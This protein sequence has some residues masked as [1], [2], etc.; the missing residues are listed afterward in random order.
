MLVLGVVGWGALGVLIGALMRRLADRITRAHRANPSTAPP[1][2]FEAITAALFAG[3]AWRTGAEPQLLAYSYLAAIGVPLAAID[4]AVG[5]LPN[6]LI[7]PSY[8]ALIGLFG[9]AAAAVHD[10]SSMLRAIA[11]MIIAAGFY[12]LLYV[13]APGQLGGGDVKLGGLL[14]L[15]LGWASWSTLLTGTLLG[16]LLAAVTQLALGAVGRQ[17]ADRQVRLGP[18]LIIGTLATLLVIGDSR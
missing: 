12:L 14:G 13:A 8:L 16:W 9:L 6:Q 17:S 3:L 5:R 11:G 4:L 1:L 10:T 7:L 18:F 2:V 15:A